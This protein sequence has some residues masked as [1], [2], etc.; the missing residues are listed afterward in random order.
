MLVPALSDS[1]AADDF[2]ARCGLAHLDFTWTLGTCASL[3]HYMEA[4]EHVP[5][6]LKERTVV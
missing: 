4:G 3:D 5:Q 6:I 2:L 1:G